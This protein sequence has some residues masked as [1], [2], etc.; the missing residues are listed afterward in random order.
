MRTNLRKRLFHFDIYFLLNLL[1]FVEVVWLT[2]DVGT[3][4]Y[5]FQQLMSTQLPS[6]FIGKYGKIE[7]RMCVLVKIKGGREKKFKVPFIVFKPFD[8]NAD[9]SLRVCIKLSLNLHYR[10]YLF[11]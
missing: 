4:N 10:F 5:P 11:K 3:Y 9:Q 6:S 8:L 7:Y 1:D 2:P